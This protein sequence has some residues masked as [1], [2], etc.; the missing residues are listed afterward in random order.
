MVQSTKST[1]AGSDFSV[2]LLAFWVKG[3]VSVDNSFLRVDIPNTILFGLIP[4]GKNKDTSPLSGIT[5]IYTSSS[6]KLGAIF[7]GVILALIGFSSFSNSALLG[8][9]LLLLGVVLVGSGIKTSLSYE[10]SGIIKT[11]EFPFFEANHVRE[12]EEEITNK[13][14]AFQDDR[15]VR[16][17]T[18]KTMAQSERHTKDIVNAINGNDSTSSDNAST[19]KFCPNCG[20]LL[21]DDAKFCTHCGTKIQ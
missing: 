17:Q 3:N 20:S 18:E 9:V 7:L 2:S 15:N 13:L 1:N 6:Y 5:N 16:M 21:A 19:G 12:L 14:Q 8:F 4:A 10:R 11:I